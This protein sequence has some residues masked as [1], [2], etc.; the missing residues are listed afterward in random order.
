MIWVLWSVPLCER[1]K[2]G[3]LDQLVAEKGYTWL[4]Y[5]FPP[6]PPFLT[7]T[8]CPSIPLSLSNRVLMSPLPADPPPDTVIQG[9]LC[10]SLAP[11]GRRFLPR[12]G[13]NKAY[14][15]TARA[16]EGKRTVTRY[17]WNQICFTC[18]A[19]M[20]IFHAECQHWT[21]GMQLLTAHLTG[22]WNC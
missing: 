15:V 2:K 22:L 11:L 17:K 5:W 1:K 21:K 9:S 4:V 10:P 8:L 6:F 14:S 19:A 3:N 13:G 12:P 7:P 20:T 18:P 16:G